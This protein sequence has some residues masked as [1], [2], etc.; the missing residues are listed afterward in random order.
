MNLL[1]QYITEIHSVEKCEEGWTKKFDK[2]FIKA[3][4]TTNCYGNE[5]TDDHIFDT[6]KWE[7]VKKQGYFMA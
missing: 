7:K 1:E 5:K 6:E 4:L 3:K 2:E